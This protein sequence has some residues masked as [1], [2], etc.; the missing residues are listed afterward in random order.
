MIKHD[1]ERGAF[2]RVGSGTATQRVYLN[3]VTFLSMPVDS[4]TGRSGSKRKRDSEAGAPNILAESG[5]ADAPDITAKASAP[6]AIPAEAETEAAS[7][8]QSD[9]REKAWVKCYFP[10]KVGL[11]SLQYSIILY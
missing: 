8:S 10:S 11:F 7:Q 2:F 6:T 3:Q 4:T 1:S 5:D 9:L